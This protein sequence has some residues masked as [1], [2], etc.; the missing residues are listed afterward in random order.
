MTRLALLM[1]MTVDQFV[2]YTILSVRQSIIVVQT[3]RDSND[4]LTAM[5]GLWPEANVR[6]QYRKGQD[7]LVR[8][9][10]NVRDK[11]SMFERQAINVVRQAINVLGTIMS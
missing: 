2:Q 11:Q 1:M 7:R 8:Q 3:G 4:K 6:Q 9:E 10:I 5:R